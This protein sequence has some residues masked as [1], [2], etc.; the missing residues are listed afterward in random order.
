M[1]VAWSTPSSAFG[2]R[3]HGFSKDNMKA[4]LLDAFLGGV[5]TSS[6][7]SYQFDKSVI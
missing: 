4:I 6:A 3:G 2:S 1:A 7:S 5:D